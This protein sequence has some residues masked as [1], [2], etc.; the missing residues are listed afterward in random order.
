MPIHPVRPPEWIESASTVVAESIDI[1]AT[2]EEVWTH[3]ADHAA[4]PEW[5]TA[6][7]RVDPGPIAAGVGGTRRVSAS[8]LTIDEQF[9]AWD[10]AAHFAFAVTGSNLPVL[11]SLAE[12]V[13]LTSTDTGCRVTYRQGV[14]GRRGLDWVMA[15]IWS[16]AALA[17]PTAL[18][19]LKRR[20]E[21]DG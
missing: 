2:P 14:Q 1:A 21:A 16:R 15:R 11:G 18:E 17:L 7:T 12:S 3:I 10:E 20:V 6:L 4:W 19:N 8:V 13:R 5:F 9:T